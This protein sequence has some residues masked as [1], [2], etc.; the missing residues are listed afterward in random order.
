[1]RRGLGCLVC[2]GEPR[3]PAIVPAAAHDAAMWPVWPGRQVTVGQSTILRGA[4]Q[5]CTPR[6]SGRLGRHLLTEVAGARDWCCCLLHVAVRRPWS[7]ERERRAGGSG[8]SGWDCVG[9]AG[10]QSRRAHRETGRAARGHGHR[11][12]F[13]NQVLRSDRACFQRD[14]ANA[15]YKDDKRGL[16]GSLGGGG[17]CREGGTAR[18]WRCAR[19]SRDARRGGGAT[20]SA[21]RAAWAS[22]GPQHST[23]SDPPPMQHGRSECA[24]ETAEADGGEKQDLGQTVFVM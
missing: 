19:V 14:Y 7:G 12:I 18:G 24:G 16:R 15:I 21:T 2:G 13:R 11:R 3:W 22:P 6:A 17:C 1:M 9:C 20:R 8:R 4:W 5:L 10:R 23:R